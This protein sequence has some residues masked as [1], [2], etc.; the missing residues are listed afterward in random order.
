MI[1]DAD[2]KEVDHYLNA[3]FGVIYK[4]G[5]GGNGKA[6]YS[7]VANAL[8]GKASGSI[9]SL[10][11]ISPLEHILRVKARSK[12][13]IPYP[14]SNSTTTKYG[15]TFAD[16]GEGTITANGTATENAIYYFGWYT[17]N[18]IVFPKGKYTFSGLPSGSAYETYY[19]GF[20]FVDGENAKDK[21][22]YE[23]GTTIEL[24]KVR[25]FYIVVKKGITVNNLVFKPQLELDTKATH[26]TLFVPIGSIVKNCTIEEN[27]KAYISITDIDKCIA[28]SKAEGRTYTNG[29]ESFEVV[30]NS[31]GFY[32]I[33]DWQ[34]DENELLNQWGIS[35]L[36]QPE[37]D[38]DSYTFTILY[39]DG[40]NINAV[41]TG[42]NF[43]QINS[44]S[45]PVNKDKT[46][47][48]KGKISGDFV[49][50]WKNNLT[51]IAQSSSSLIGWMYEDGSTDYD[52]SIN[53]SK[54]FVKISNKTITQIFVTN[55]S[56]A[57][58][59]S[60]D[61]IQL[62]VGKTQTD[63]EPY[64]E[65]KTYLINAD[66]TVEGV[67]SIYPTTTITSDT[68]G[69]VFDVEY[70]RDINKAFAELHNAIISLGGN[71]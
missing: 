49:L 34:G 60:V 66:G 7:V 31:E 1:L 43:A 47:V 38:Q 4:V 63:Y 30:F 27:A 67:T 50:S 41:V 3:D 17:T 9:V 11:D 19:L 6:D 55:W 14:F 44:V 22:I 70:N 52:V 26:Y 23:N 21:G 5:E 59:G 56:G 13:L 71:V 64:I 35:M 20:S 61:N 29:T 45:F 28:K 2:F 24:E 69:V 62:E 39:K 46:I 58:G 68:E 25:A 53:N 57:T 48:F 32:L 42:K 54:G 8:K 37:A 10:T 40:T 65:P 33:G 16:D 15:I 51:G 36:R 18:P 12:N